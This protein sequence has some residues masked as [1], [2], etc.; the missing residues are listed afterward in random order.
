MGF[1][2][3]KFLD[4]FN[5]VFWQKKLD[6]FEHFG[7]GNGNGDGFSWTDCNSWSWKKCSQSLL[8]R[9]SQVELVFV[10]YNATPRLQ[11]Y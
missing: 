10:L 8:S 9:G 6:G 7:E 2:L 11:L 5:G 4:C 3:N 1:A